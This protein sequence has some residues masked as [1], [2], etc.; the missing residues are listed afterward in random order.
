MIT[1]NTFNISA[2]NNDHNEF[3]QNR[4]DQKTKPQGALGKLELLAFQLAR[5]LDTSKIEI[6]KPTMLVFA[7]DHGIAEEGISIAPSVVTTQMV[8]NFLQGGAAINCFTKVNNI[9]L[10]V[11]NAGILGDVEDKRLIQQP[12]GKITKNFSK[13]PAMTMD[14]VVEG[15]LLGKNLVSKLHQQGSNLIGL[16]EMGIGNTTSASALMSALLKIPADESVGR[17]TGINNEQ[18]DKKIR[19]I[20]QALDLHAE[21]LD[22]PLDILACVGGFEIVQMVGA[23]LSAA[24]HKMVVLVDG[25][26]TTAAALVACHIHKE[27]KDY[28]V[29]C[30][31]SHEQGHKRMLTQLNAQALLDL[32]LRLGEGT[33]AALAFPL[34]KAAAEFYNNMAS[35]ES[36]GVIAV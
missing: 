29:F 12:L 18:L 9:D 3:I 36:A 33:G 6:N 8:Q 25:F 22:C 28:L 32:D 35:F 2:L 23:I 14:Q 7:G 17:G 10:K 31:Q 34:V 27:T 4:I 19:L 24:E 30:H 21:K 20:N 16:G 15:I 11:I 13:E 1:P 26:I 5:I